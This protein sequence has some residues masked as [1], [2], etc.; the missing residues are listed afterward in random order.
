MVEVG[1]FILNIMLIE[2]P[3][4]DY[5]GDVDF[6]QLSVQSIEIQ[7]HIGVASSIF[8]ITLFSRIICFR[9]HYLR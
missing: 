2:L 4:N 7:I 3:A 6:V 1:I 8:L 9:I 5:I